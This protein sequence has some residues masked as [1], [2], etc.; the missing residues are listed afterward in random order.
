MSNPVYR[1]AKM[2][3][4]MFIS[5]FRLDNGDSWNCFVAKQLMPSFV[6]FVWGLSGKVK[7][8]RRFSAISR[9]EEVVKTY[10]NIPNWSWGTQNFSFLDEVKPAADDIIHEHEWNYMVPGWPAEIGAADTIDDWM[11]LASPYFLYENALNAIEQGFKL[12][13]KV[14]VLANRDGFECENPKC[15]NKHKDIVDCLSERCR[16]SFRHDL[17]KVYYELTHRIRS[18]NGH[19]VNCTVKDFLAYRWHEILRSNAFGSCHNECAYYE[20]SRLVKIDSETACLQKWLEKNVDGKVV[21]RYFLEPPSYENRIPAQFDLPESEILALLSALDVLNQN[22][23]LPVFEKRV[24]HITG[25][26]F[27]PERDNLIKSSNETD[28]GRVLNE[29][30]KDDIVRMLDFNDLCYSCYSGWASS[31]ITI[32]RDY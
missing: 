29:F 13:Y 1:S 18:V 28:S 19:P 20:G 21:N 32:I 3:W 23:A 24:T 27:C 16:R 9:F 10:D 5:D 4:I 30:Q 7:F 31:R 6:T 14:C 11:R 22:I 8:S 26:W 15:K 25:D 12:I 2:A 17:S